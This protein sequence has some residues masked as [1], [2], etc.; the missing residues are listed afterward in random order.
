MLI[1]VMAIV[2]MI[3]V[4]M[5]IVGMIIV[6]MAIVTMLKVIMLSVMASVMYSKRGSS[7]LKCAIKASLVRNNSK[8]LNSKM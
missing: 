8:T 3:I 4:V 1:V 2:G 5:A 6:V 7:L